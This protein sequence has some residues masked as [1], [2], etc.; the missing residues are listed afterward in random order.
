MPAPLPLPGP[1]WSLRISILLLVVFLGFRLLIGFHACLPFRFRQ[2]ERLV[3]E[4][5]VE[6]IIHHNHLESDSAELHGVTNPD[7]VPLHQIKP[8]AIP[9]LIDEAACV[10]SGVLDNEPCL[11]SRLLPLLLEVLDDPLMK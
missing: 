11:A 9:Y 5:S 3:D 4:F 10:I 8:R 1:F 7:L 6:R 2:F